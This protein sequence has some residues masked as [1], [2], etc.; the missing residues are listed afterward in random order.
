[1]PYLNSSECIDK[2]IVSDMSGILCL[3]KAWAVHNEGML[4]RNKIISTNQAITI[5]GWLDCISYAWCMVLDSQ[6]ENM[7]F[8]PYTEEYKV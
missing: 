4:L 7:A 6:D 1:V 5:D 2:N 3:G 8:E